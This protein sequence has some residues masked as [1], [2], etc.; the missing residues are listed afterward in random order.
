MCTAVADT[1]MCIS[2]ATKPQFPYSAI[3]VRKRAAPWPVSTQAL[4]KEGDRTAFDV[5]KCTG[6]GLC[7]LACPFGVVWTDKIAHKCDLCEGRDAPTCVT[8]CPANAL[9]TDFELAS[10]R[11]RARAALAVA[12]GG[13]R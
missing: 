4:H 2:P 13:R 10:R 12:H 11:A 7:R 5:E 9:S 1:S 6:C 3:T 8:T